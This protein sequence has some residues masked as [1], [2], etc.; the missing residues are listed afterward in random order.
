MK[1]QKTRKPTTEFSAINS[2]LA[3][4]HQRA[5]NKKKSLEQA[6]KKIGKIFKADGVALWIVEEETQF[7]KIAVAVGLSDRYL[8]YFNKTD[9]I[10]VGHGI[11][12]RVIQQRETILSKRPAIDKRIKLIRWREIIQEEGICAFLSTPMFIGLEK[13]GTLNIYYKQPTHHFTLEEI[14]LTEILAYHFAL[15][16][17]QDIAY[18][19]KE[20]THQELAEYRKRILKLR[21][22]TEFLSL[23]V[24][25][26]F[27]KALKRIVKQTLSD[28]GGSGIAIFQKKN[29][30]LVLVESYGFSVYAQQYLH[31]Y[32]LQIN[33]A[34]SGDRVFTA[35]QL[36]MSSRVLTDEQVPKFW[37]TL[38]ANEGFVSECIFPLEVR[39]N[40]V[41]ILTTYY[42]QEHVYSSEEF[43][44]LD[45]IAH[46]L[47]ISL[48]NFQIFLS[49]QEKINELE[50][51]YKLTVGRELKMIELKKE[52]E[53]LKEKVK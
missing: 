18:R 31:E 49:L 53:E 11:V 9:R 10:H 26:S 43:G 23:G 22:V 13:I 32:P 3:Q 42:R 36:Q 37:K 15:F 7:M 39:D 35:E 14:E 34:V 41:G 45:T 33:M 21:D 51:F 16:F 52:I 30:K 29:K 28:F 19:Q 4:F 6:I 44:V 12:G 17:A 47:A 40:P 50:R 20:S 8:R 46:F 24:R 25:G 1:K 5:E 27:K 38:L 2:L 48:E